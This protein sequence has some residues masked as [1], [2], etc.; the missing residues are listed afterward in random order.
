MPCTAQRGNLFDSAR[1]AETTHTTQKIRP[2]PTRAQ[3]QRAQPLSPLDTG[4]RPRA[5]PNPSPR[6]ALPRESLGR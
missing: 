4:R 6:K 2:P 3:A 5:P 1:G